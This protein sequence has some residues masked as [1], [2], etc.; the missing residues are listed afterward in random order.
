MVYA[1]TKIGPMKRCSI[2]GFYFLFI[3]ILISFSVSAQEI[4]YRFHHLTVDEGL[5]HTD[6]TSIAQDQQGFIWIGTYRGLNRFDGYELKSFVNPDYLP[7]KCIYQSDHRFVYRPEEQDLD[8][9]PGRD[10]MFRY[11]I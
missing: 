9:Y 4:D 10:R 3:F 7:K 8:G 2:P 1:L 5:A 11:C 6:A